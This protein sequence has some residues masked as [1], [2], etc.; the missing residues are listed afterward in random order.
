MDPT[1][2]S[3]HLTSQQEEGVRAFILLYVPFGYCANTENVE[4]H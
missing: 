2:G 3:S 4:G 1:E